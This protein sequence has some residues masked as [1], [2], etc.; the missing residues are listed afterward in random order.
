MAV[1]TSLRIWW[2]DYNHECKSNGWLD[3]LNEPDEL[4]KKCYFV[5]PELPVEPLKKHL[6]KIVV[7]LPRLIE[8]P[9]K[10]NF[11]VEVVDIRDSLSALAETFEWPDA[12]TWDN[13]VLTI[14]YDVIEDSA[15]AYF[16]IMLKLRE[17]W[18]V[19]DAHD[20]W[21]FVHKQMGIQVTLQQRE[22]QIRVSKYL[23][24]SA[25]KRKLD[26]LKDFKFTDGAHWTKPLP[27]ALRD[28]DDDTPETRRKIR[29]HAIETMF[30]EWPRV[31]LEDASKSTDLHEQMEWIIM[32][33]RD[34]D[35]IYQNIVLMNRA[36]KP[37]TESKKKF[38]DIKKVYKQ[39][40]RQLAP[41]RRALLSATFL[42]DLKAGVHD[43]CLTKFLKTYMSYST[44]T[45]EYQMYLQTA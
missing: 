25:P 12:F 38:R 40:Q 7:E 8:S 45:K 4:A 30:T 26:L 42:A 39:H 24:F 41:M 6:H 19:S 34:D 10:P 23:A 17:S 3:P 44:A 5:L 33:M 15:L 43:Q 9:N 13:D 20:V 1:R 29:E 21:D 27:E 2:E 31:S 35:T 32:N 28:M 22:Q 11:V 37:T 16:C 14:N 36:I 18:L